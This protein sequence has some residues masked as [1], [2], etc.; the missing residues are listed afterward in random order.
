M[1]ERRPKNEF[2]SRL[3]LPSQI[4]RNVHPGEENCFQAASLWAYKRRIWVLSTL[5]FAELPGG[6]GDGAGRFSAPMAGFGHE[7]GRF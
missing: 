5:D 1:T 2:W 3:D 7:G 4:A 6:R